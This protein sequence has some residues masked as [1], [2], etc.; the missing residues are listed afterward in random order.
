MWFCPMTSPWKN[1]EKLTVCGNH[2]D[3]N[4]LFMGIFAAFFPGSSDPTHLLFVC[5]CVRER[6]PELVPNTEV[7]AAVI[8]H[9]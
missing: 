2:T 6:D 4:C 9:M 1:V 7:W 5:V 3:V 8:V